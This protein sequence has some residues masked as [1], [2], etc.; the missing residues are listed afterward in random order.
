V[1]TVLRDGNYERVSF[2]RIL[3]IVH[4]HR[5]VDRARQRAQDLTE[6][7]RAIITTFP[8][9]AAQ[10]ALVTVTDLVTDRDH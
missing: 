1:E 2:S 4:N 5:G 6:A 10:R 8:D 3:R 7:A 9:S